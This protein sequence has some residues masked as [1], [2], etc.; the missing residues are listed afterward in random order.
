MDYNKKITKAFANAL[1]LP[2]NSSS[3]YVL[4][5]DCHR[6]CGNAND[7]FLKNE[8]LYLAALR[9]YYEKEFIYIELGDGD[10]LWENRSI[11]KIKEMHPKSFAMLS[12]FY[13]KGQFYSLYGNHDMIKKESDFS[14]QSFSSYYHNELFC[15]CPLFP[16]MPFYESIILRGEGGYKDIYLLHGH[17]AS[18]LNSTF[19]KLSRFLVRYLWSPLERIGILD[20]TSAANNY[21]IKKKTEQRLSQWKPDELNPVLQNDM[22][23]TVSS[24]KKQVTDEPPAS[25]QKHILISGH[26]HRPMIASAN[27]SYCNTGSVIHPFGITCIEIEDGM[28]SL[29]KWSHQINQNQYIHVGREVLGKIPIM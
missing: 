16:S 1:V 21:S 5:S 11:E 19:W 8:L 14:K 6:G 18:L 15:R 23:K 20:P 3:R 2:L 25:I 17:Q 29:V 24:T 28:I 22:H 10:E 26:T 9:N 12:K 7:N 13:Q 27:S 4:F